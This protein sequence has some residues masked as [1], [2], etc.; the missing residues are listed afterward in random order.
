MNNY[1]IKQKP[2]DVIVDM[3]LPHLQKAGFVEEN[4]S[5]E[6][7]ERA[8]GI[9]GLYQEQMSYCA[10]I[11]PLSALFFLEEV[12]YDEDAKDVLK[13][14]Q[15]PVVLSSFKN[16]LE[17]A[18]EYTGFATDKGGPYSSVLR[19]EIGKIAQEIADRLGVS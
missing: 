2:L 10:Q 3:C 16:H 19:M 9:V 6:E 4:P 11:V 13:E 5:A 8:R 17:A 7:M 1:Y 15:V 18:S 12:V 14:E